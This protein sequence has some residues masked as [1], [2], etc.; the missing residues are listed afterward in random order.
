MAFYSS[1][2]PKIP[3]STRQSLHRY[4]HLHAQTPAALPYTEANIPSITVLSFTSP[5]SPRL[6]V[7]IKN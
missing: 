4:L 2:R 7:N 1:V 6:S 3:A 5:F